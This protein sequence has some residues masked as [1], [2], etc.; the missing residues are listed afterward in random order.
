[1]FY[2]V[3]IKYV[4]QECITMNNYGYYLSITLFHNQPPPI[5]K[6]SF[7]PSSSPLST[8]PN[9]FIYIFIQTKH[10]YSYQKH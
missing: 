10:P 1:M 7:L 6:I 2:N 8:L 9:L 3:L 4:I 5:T